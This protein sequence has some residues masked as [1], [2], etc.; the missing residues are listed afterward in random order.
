MVRFCRCST[1]EV[2]QCARCLCLDR[3]GKWL[4]NMFH[5]PAA[6]E[7]R[8]CACFKL[9]SSFG[10]VSRTEKGRSHVFLSGS[11]LSILAKGALDPLTCFSFIGP[12]P[13]PSH[14]RLTLGGGW[15]LA[16]GIWMPFSHNGKR[17]IATYPHGTWTWQKEVLGLDLSFLRGRHS[18][19]CKPMPMLDCS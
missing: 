4:P 17:N 11:S 6:S 7:L 15:I 3:A 19:F 2:F 1:A 13:P 12:T 14:F 16:A 5:N 9:V 8:V 10:F 18:T